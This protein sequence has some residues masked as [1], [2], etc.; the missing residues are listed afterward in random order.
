MPKPSN[1]LGKLMTL[2]IIGYNASGQLGNLRARAI[3]FKQVLSFF[4]Y[5]TTNLFE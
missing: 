3:T 5:D 1:C 2:F 4:D